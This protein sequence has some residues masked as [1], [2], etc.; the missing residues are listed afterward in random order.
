MQEPVA[1][2]PLHDVKLLQLPGSQDTPRYLSF[3]EENTDVVPFSIRRVYWLH[4]LTQGVVR[5]CHGHKELQQL[6]VCLSGSVDVVLRDCEDSRNYVLDCP[7]IG[8]LLPAGLWREVSISP[9]SKT[10][11]SVMNL[12]SMLYD[13]SDYMRTFN[14]YCTWFKSRNA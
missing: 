6:M 9:Y 10:N 13:E 3:V 7:S 12:A 1:R 4:D 8:L 11:A 5:G 14:E 2:S